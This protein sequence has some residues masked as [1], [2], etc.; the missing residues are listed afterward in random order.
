M[1]FRDYYQLLGVSRD[2]ST[3][4]I[5]RAYRK[6]ARKFHPD[7]SSEAD[8]E[9]RFKEIGE[10]YEVLKDPEKR[11]AYDQF[12]KD[13]QAGQEFRPPP[14]WDAGFEF[15]G[16]G[17]R[18]S[19]FSDFFE[20]LFGSGRMGGFSEHMRHPKGEDHH[21]KIM[22]SLTDAYSGATRTLT[23]RA[24]EVT[25]DGHVTTRER[26]IKVN[27]PKGVTN[28]QR[29]RLAGQGSA[30]AGRG[31]PGDLYLEIGLEPHEFF[32]ASGRDIHLDLPI[33]PWEAALGAKV[34]VPTLGGNVDLTIPSNSRPGRKLRLKGRGLPGRPD[35]DQFVTLRIETPEA[36]DAEKEDFYRRMSE[37]MPLDP[38][39]N[40]HL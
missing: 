10:A 37:L 8:A 1:K 14:G 36:D 12:G 29:I 2:A 39:K 23:L 28:G 25:A 18:A 9:E 26:S 27:I 21:A 31:Q 24:P 3:D 11:T 40:L 19:G 15:A 5:K 17:G 6:L 16:A 38:R 22:I 20:S 4:E 35:G 33:T 13:W 7:V 32:A 34:A 30:G